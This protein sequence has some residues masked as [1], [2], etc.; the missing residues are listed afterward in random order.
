[1]IWIKTPGG[2]THKIRLASFVGNTVNWQIDNK[3][4]MVAAGDSF[5]VDNDKLMF[6]ILKQVG[7]QFLI[8]VEDK[9]GY[10]LSLNS[11]DWCS[12]KNAADIVKGIDKI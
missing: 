1:M 7:D 10:Q 5:Q 2:V 12:I 6:I 11:F 9:G 8:G 3:I 4:E